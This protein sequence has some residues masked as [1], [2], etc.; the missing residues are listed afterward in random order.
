MNRLSIQIPRI[1]FRN[2]RNVSSIELQEKYSE[3]NP[4]DKNNNNY[5]EYYNS[6]QFKNKVNIKDNN[7]SK[8]K[9]DILK[10]IS[11]RDIPLL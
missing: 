3:K 2:S 1:I 9:P 7:K 11:I 8:Y 4:Y 6:K 5:N 10:N